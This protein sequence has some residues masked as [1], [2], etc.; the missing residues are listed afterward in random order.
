[1][2]LTYRILL[3]FMVLVLALTACQTQTITPVAPTQP[4]I[5]SPTAPAEPTPTPATEM[6]EDVLYL[7]LMW[8][9]H[10]PLY[11]KDENGV[12]TRPWVRVHA[13][14]DYYD[15]AYLVSQYPNVHVTFNLTPVLLRQLEDFVNNGAKDL[16]WVMT[17][18]PANQL[19][20]DDKRFILQRFFDA[21]WDKLIGRY[22]RYKEL[23]E[24]RGGTDAEAIQNALTTFTEQDFRDLQIWWNLVWFDPMFLNQPPLKDLV[25]KGRNFSEEDKEIIFREARRIMAETVPLHRKL[26]EAGQIEVTTTP[27]AHPILPLLIDGLLAVA[28]KSI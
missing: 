4:V 25:E 13:T 23:L 22:P 20:E 6:A 12:Y 1:M 15:M 9:Q 27:Y 21:N 16:Y 24:K 5:V 8:H 14:K 10:Q 7:N 11:Y 17:E 2:K 18:K 19:S 26:Q 3:I 28:C